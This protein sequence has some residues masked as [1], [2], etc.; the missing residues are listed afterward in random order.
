MYENITYDVILDRMLSRVSD[1]FDKREGSVIFDAHSPA[2]IELQLLYLELDAIIR[3]SY[4][5][6]ASREFLVRRCAERGITPYPASCAVLKGVFTPQNIDVSGKRFNIGE[7]NFSVFEKIT[8]GV[9]KVKCETSGTVG[10][11]R[12]GSMIPIEYIPG[13]ETAELTE[14]LIPGENE[15]DVENLRKRYFDSFSDKA[16]GGN[17]R[18][19]IEKTG[20]IPG[21]G[22]VKVTR[23]WNSGISPSAMIPD[24]TVSQWYEN[25]IGSAPNENVKKWLTSVFTAAKEKKLTTGGTVLLTI[26]NS[27]FEPAS[28]TLIKTVQETI[29]PDE[30]AGEGM[31][32]APIGHI[33]NV[34]SADILTVSVK[35]SI[36]FSKGHDWSNLQKPIN[37]AVSQYLLELRK[38]WAD[39]DYAIVRISQIEIRILQIKG[40]LDIENTTLNGIAK[41]LVCGVY[42]VPVLEG[43]SE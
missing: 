39:S 11:Q 17:V 15:E 22:G 30:Y 38:A 37:D 1:K 35:T 5:D 10:N 8:D 32:L 9:Y 7:I 21:V 4:G 18:D 20:S 27:D 43:V 6:T 19:Y 23:V 16:F 31:G 25:F 40:V 33:V 36:T 26:L 14:I 34:R 24:E 28:E 41:N 3:E 29:D 12:L 2:A 13:L 42:Q